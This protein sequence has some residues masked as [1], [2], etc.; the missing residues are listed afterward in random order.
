MA[1]DSQCPFHYAASDSVTVQSVQQD[2]A[3]RSDQSPC[4]YQNVAGFG[5]SNRDWW[6]NQL[7]VSILHKNSCLSDPMDADFD[8]AAAFR[9]L[10]FAAL[11]TDLTSLMTTSQPWW[12][13]DFGHYGPFFIR[14]AWHSAGTYRI[15]DGR[16]G[17]NTGQQ[18]FAPL[19]SWPDNGNLDKAR[20]LLWPIKQ[21][22]GRGISW[23]D[24]I[25]L[26]GNVAL[27]SMGVPTLGFAGGRVDVWEADEVTNWG[28]ENEQLS[29]RDRVPDSYDATELSHPLGALMSG[30]IYVNPQGPRG[31]PSTHQA[32]LDIRETFR[33]MGMNDEETLAL[34][35][36]GHT[37]GKTHGAAAPGP[38]VGAEPNA[39]GLEQQ[40][41][42]W[43]NSFGQG[44]GND[45]IT[46]GLEVTWT[47]TPTKWSRFFLTN[48]LELKWEL[49]R[50][51]AG[52][53]QW[54]PTTSNLRVPSAQPGGSTP[55][56][57]M[58]TTDLALRDDPI[59]GPIARRW[60]AAAAQGDDQLLNAFENAWY[61]LIHRDLGPRSRYI[62]PA[63]ELRHPAAVIW[64]DPLPVA[65]P[66]QLTPANIDWLKRELAQ[67]WLPRE[68]VFTAWA[69]AST[70]RDSDKRGGAN[71]ARLSLNPQR[72]WAVNEPTLLRLT[73][74]RLQR[75]R[76]RFAGA[77]NNT[78]TLADLIVLGG[79]VG[80]EQAASAAGVQVSVPFNQGRRDA[81]QAQTEPESFAVLEPV[82]DGFRNYSSSEACSAIAERLLLDKAQLL[83]LTAPE[84][85]VL[86][87]GLRVL[88]VN[89]DE[90][91][92]GV[93]TTP[94]RLGSLTNDFFTNLL[95]MGT[96][97]RPT[98]DT[99]VLFE[100]RPRGQPNAPVRWTATRVDLVFGSHPELRAVSEVYASNDGQEKFVRDFVAAWVKVMELDRF[101]L[102]PRP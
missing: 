87:G 93:F 20:R 25:I 64:Q 9:A 6:P 85:T 76:T 32:A 26:A 69:A 49:H 38:Y 47:T 62:I 74:Q 53:H 72:S 95:D 68:L 78:I 91:S 50:S 12:P 8:Y 100:G 58:L 57:G 96:E 33:R 24:L 75:L 7:D 97:W 34:I 45:T 43:R 31:V 15:G 23:A 40:G 80:V 14:M 5:R 79:N 54:R 73:L 67:D 29:D 55:P 101:D 92:H 13:A 94:E 3:A 10:D 46:S 18:R 63:T 51:P 11:K 83:T 22:Y 28:S 42:G 35:A 17:A 81:T 89:T 30:L 48:L 36:G 2:R 44:H 98:T 52:A 84:M 1:N 102:P 71:G 37:F 19:N 56:P 4:P 90:S 65:A 27:E 59:Y 82:A 61:K 39:A 21:K 77:Q 60:H 16:G 86:I 41:L 66:P 99:S 70:Y 88:G